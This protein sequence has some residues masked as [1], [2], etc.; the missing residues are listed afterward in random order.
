MSS[1]R[2]KLR[3]A[4]PVEFGLPGAFFQSYLLVDLFLHLA[5]AC[6]TGLPQTDNDDEATPTYYGIRRVEVPVVI[7]RSTKRAE[8]VALC[9]AA[10]PKHDYLPFKFTMFRSRNSSRVVDAASGGFVAPLV[11]PNFV[12]GI[13]LEKVISIN[14]S[15]HKNG[16]IC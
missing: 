16:L 9:A 3:V 4:L 10:L 1:G 8:H 14:V 15:G 5:V 13:R 12:W 7:D 11:D 2:C 6:N